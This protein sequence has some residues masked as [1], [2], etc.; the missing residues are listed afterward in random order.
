MLSPAAQPPQQ[1]TAQFHTLLEE[2]AREG[3]AL[4]NT[5]GHALLVGVNP[6]E[7][8]DYVRGQVSPA[9]RVDV[10]QMLARS[11]WALGRVVAL[12]KAKRDPA[13]LGARILASHGQ[14]DPRAWGIVGSGDHEADLAMLLDQV[15]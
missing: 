11:P 9:N 1:G 7:I 12:V 3:I 4:R 15:V 6:E 10:D 13:S 8:L 2:S 14:V 5:A